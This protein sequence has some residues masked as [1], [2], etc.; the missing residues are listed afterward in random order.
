M[1]EA[2]SA[3]PADAAVRVESVSKQ[4]GKGG[5]GKHGHRGDALDAAA[6]A[7]G[8]E[9]DALKD[10]LKEGRTLAQVAESQGVDVQVVID[11]LVAEG[12]ARIDAA[13]ANG[14]LGAD[15]A[16]ERKAQLAERIA[17]RVSTPHE[18]GG[19]DRD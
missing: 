8:M 19:R 14:R 18:R 12:N 17:E 3:P 6:T 9:P 7:L 15:E 16:E 13:V 1:T 2:A 11:A 5:G 10:A 4:F